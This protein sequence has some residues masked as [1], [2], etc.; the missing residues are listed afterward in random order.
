MFEKRWS[1][2]QTFA[3]FLSWVLLF[4]TIDFFSF[5]NLNFLCVPECVFLLFLVMQH[6]AKFQHRTGL[7]RSLALKLEV[8]QAAIGSKL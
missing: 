8:Y 5:F 4:G 7:F 6:A 2:V 1:W 3:I